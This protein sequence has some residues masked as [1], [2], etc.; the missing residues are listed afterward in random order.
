MKLKRNNKIKFSKKAKRT[1]AVTNKSINKKIKNKKVKKKEKVK[2][3]KN[4]NKAI[5]ERFPLKLK[6]TISHTLA[7]I[8]PILIISL[9]LLNIVKSTMTEQVENN[10]TK[11]MNSINENINMK[12]KEIEN[13]SMVIMS[14]DSLVKTV[15]KSKDDY[16]NLFDMLKERDSLINEK[17]FSIQYSNTSIQNI[18]IVKKDETIEC[19]ATHGKIS[20]G[21]FDSDIYK[22]VSEARG[23][24]V[25]LSNVYDNP[26]SIYLMRKLTRISTAHEIGVLIIEVKKSYLTEVFENLEDKTDEFIIDENGVI[27]Y[28]ADPERLKQQLEIYGEIESRIE[29]E[30]DAEIVTGNITIEGQ[31]TSFVRCSNNWFYV[32]QISKKDF[33]GVID[34]IKTNI[35]LLGL[36]ISVIAIILSS[37][38]SLNISYP[39]KYIRNKMKLVE[40]G[41]LTAVSNI[42]GKYDMGQLSHSYNMMLQSTKNLINNN[43]DLTKVVSDNSNQV[44]EI[45]RHSAAGSREVTIAVESVSQG[46]MEQARDAE[47]AA[48]VVKKFIDKFNETEDYFNKVVEATEDTKE[49][50]VQATDIIKELND[51]TVDATELSNNFKKDILS[52][53]DKF[54][55]ILKIIGL[56]DGISEQSNLLALN[57][58]IEAARAGEAGKGFAVVADEVR[59]LA[60]QSKDAAKDISLI[61]GKVHTATSETAK[62]IEEGGNIF[63]RQQEAVNKTDD[64]FGII[65]KNMDQIKNKVDQVFEML[66]GF[67]EIQDEAITSITSIA[68]IA[69][70][71]AAAIEEVLATGEEQTSSAE[72]LVNMSGELAKVIEEMNN[73]L[74]EFK[75]D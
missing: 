9:F 26:E 37:I 15:S 20:E 65:V 58:A 28:N 2:S 47:N 27:V 38:V 57:A 51:S 59:K 6:L 3:I 71:S 33:L 75:I 19:R 5:K 34:R 72:Q 1:K 49:I 35:L 69:Q 40:D 22:T 55:E 14:D 43:R 45:A 73:S 4:Y 62:M 25:W 48:N 61:V 24:A 16:E 11:L 42:K 56:I 30:D 7:A 74:D 13:T 44:A 10:N 29:E 70:E 18:I 54:K 52:L 32:E 68:S 50:S 41:D 31:M 17:L 67:D 8:L 64:A 12:L 60:V 46:A 39:I 21:F 53:V 66:A 36:V 63:V 23:R